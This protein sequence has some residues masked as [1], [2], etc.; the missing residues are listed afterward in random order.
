MENSTLN[1]KTLLLV[2]TASK[3][4]KFIIQRLKKLGIKLVVLNKEKNW[5]DQYVDHWIFSDTY[6]HNESIAAIQSFIKTHPKVKIDGVIT[7]WEDDVLLTSKIVDRFDFIGIP[8]EVAKNVRNKFLFREFCTTH[9]IRSPKHKMVRTIRQLKSVT[10]YMSF[11]LVIKPAYGASS[12]Y[13]VKVTNKDELVNTYNYI[14]KNIS[15]DSESAL[16]D[17]LDIFV[18]EYIDGDEVDIDILIQNGKIK[19]YSIADNFNKN[20][21][22]FFVDSGQSVP[23][24]LPEK[25]QTELIEMAEQTLEKLKIQ[26]GCIHFEAKST[27]HGP[28]PIEINMRMGGDYVYS[29]V[30]GAWNVD[31]IECAAK[32]AMGEY[33]TIK[34][35]DRPYKFIVGWDL[36]PESSGLLAELSLS[37]ELK[38]KDYLEEIDV[39]KEVGDS[40]LLPPEGYESLGWITVSGDNLLNAQDNMKAALGFIKYKVV[41]FNQE[42]ALGKTARKNRLSAAVFKKDLLLQAAKIEKVRRI[43]LHDQRRL[44]IGIA[45]NI[46]GDMGN[47]YGDDLKEVAFAVDRELTRRGYLTTIFDFNNL[48]KVFNELRRSDVDLVLNIA[49]G[50]NNTDVL[51]PQ[52]AAILEMLHI[53]YTG[54]NSFNLALCRD[55]IRL[56]KLFSFHNIPTPKWD[57]AYD[58]KDAIKPDLQYP[59]IV[60]PANTDNSEGITH[61]S[62]V[63]NEK[64]LRKQLKYVLVDMQRP[65]L[66]EEYI[67]GDEFEVLI[68]G[69]RKDAIQVLPLSRTVFKPIRGQKKWSIYTQDAK[70]SKIGL[71]KRF[72]IQRPAKNI[73][74]KLESLLTEIALDAYNISHC[75]DYGKVELRVDKDD[76]PYVIEVNPNPPISAKSDMTL[77]AEIINMNYG[78]LLEEIIRL[79]VKR[80]NQNK[81]LYHRLIS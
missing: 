55:K 18:E 31:L 56:K 47:Y 6:N 37:A 28:V 76:N 38:G 42:S 5:A 25:E 67:H 53:P 75:K 78:D 59:L 33:I 30:K 27:K 3:K 34:K 50:I 12:A 77:S 2:N 61:E 79:C 80:Y 81:S 4:K 43:S 49:E 17:G 66:V 45:A 22:E 24:S 39:Y 1:K 21:G 65:A 11:P 60:K 23:S 73:S 44:H 9:N 71:G 74:K 19:F 16:A 48:S 57:Y 15:T 20:R 46:S 52:V 35:P 51:K 36:Y 70:W 13:V 10:R 64:Q 41:H 58:V 32:I 7:F 62:V 54:T 26:N 40:V 63:T 14:K 69:D 68:L 72:T 29:Y 8:L